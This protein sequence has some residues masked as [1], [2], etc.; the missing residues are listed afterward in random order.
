MI[1]NCEGKQDMGKTTRHNERL[2]RVQLVLNLA[3]ETREP[4]IARITPRM[5]LKMMCFS[6]PRMQNETHGM[7]DMRKMP[8][9]VQRGTQPMA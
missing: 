2:H 1:A 7:L 5:T 9:Q 3:R 6:C 8:A 4:G